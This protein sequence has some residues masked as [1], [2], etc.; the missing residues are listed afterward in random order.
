[1][2]NEE[3]LSGLNSA[4]SRGDSIKKAMMSFYNAGYKKEEI[5]EAAAIVVRSSTQNPPQNSIVSI[6]SFSGSPSTPVSQH[7]SPQKLEP[8][9]INSLFSQK[10]KQKVSHYGEEDNGKKIIVIILIALTVLLTGLFITLF[11]FKDQLINF[12]SNLFH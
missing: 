12:F 3:I 7:P 1:M 11:I 2:V 6:P 10:P 8:Q 5:E 9:K 4:L